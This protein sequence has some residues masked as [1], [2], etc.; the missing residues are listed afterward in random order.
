MSTG[1]PSAL[2]GGELAGGTSAAGRPPG[3]RSSAFALPA[4]TSFR[5]ALL[6]AAVLA[7]SV[8]VY[9]GIYLATPRGLAWVRLNRRCTSQALA[10][11]RGGMTAYAHALGQA[12]VCRSGA[13]RAEALWVVVGL[14]V[15]AVLAA[16]IYGAQP[17]WYRRRMRLA[18]LTGQDAPALMSRLEELRGHAGAGPVEWLLQPLNT[19]VSAFAFG[20]FRRRSVAVSGGAAV[21]AVRQP[22]AFDAVMLHE[23]AH[24]RNRDIS[25]TYLAVAIW[26]AFV[27]AALLPMAVLLVVGRDLGSPLRILWRVVVLA[28]TVYLLRNTI[29]RSREFDADARVQELDPDTG[30]G[31]VLDG[32]PARPGRRLW[33]LGWMHP[34]GPERATALLDPRPLYRCG[35]WDGLAVGLVTTIGASAAQDFMPQ[36]TT[37]NFLQFLVPAGLFA[38]FAAAAL[39]I[40]MWRKQLLQPQTETG[41]GGWAAGLGL[42]IGLAIGPVIALPTA[43]ANGIIPDSISLAAAGFLAAWIALTIVIYLPF[44]VWMGYWADAWQQAAGKTRR[45]PARG[46][47]I[48][49]SVA[50]WVVLTFGLY[51]LLANFVLFEGIVAE[52]LIRQVEGQVWTSTVMVTAGMTGAW[53]VCL[54]MVAV[55]LTPLL[56]SRRRPRQV[57]QRGTAWWFR[58]AVRVGALC[59]AGV[60]AAAAVTLTVSAVAHAWVAAPVR[61]DAFFLAQLIFFDTQAVVVVAV[62]FAIIAAGA[63]RSLHSFTIGVAVAAIVAALGIM[64]VINSDNIGFCVGAVSIQYTY[65]PAGLCPS[66]LGGSYLVQQMWLYAVEAALVSI[67]FIPAAHRFGGALARFRARTPKGAVVVGMIGAGAAVIVAVAATGFWGAET[68]THNI[69]PPGSIGDDGW[70]SAPGYEMR[71]SPK[72]FKITRTAYPGQ[73]FIVYSVHG[74]VIEIY[75]EPFSSALTSFQDFPR[76]YKL[77]QV[78]TRP[79]VIGGVRGPGVVGTGAGEAVYEASLVR[80]GPF[81]YVVAFT[82]PASDRA[83][84]ESELAQMLRTW[85]WKTSA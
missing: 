27:V 79:A 60:L 67:V 75:R 19:R 69:R 81:G 71:L 31:R 29:L 18:P 44:P 32:M 64:V 50:A 61:W 70:I 84:P 77:H 15:L 80:H 76:L 55:P 85:H 20:S 11:N 43:F 25:Q 5:F 73:T 45:I 16:V 52:P 72:W 23:L 59:L 42:G 38:A 30:L 34:S 54:V 26:R 39:V 28:L 3:R 40:A 22:V 62:L 2:P 33:H 68:S 13:D 51:F 12:A 10:H 24:I 46:G 4:S 53:I 14:G 56:A 35:F 57:D 63:I 37:I 8:F 83:A 65:P 74:S 21:A 41:T 36:L 47:M 7:S 78:R 48:A 9:E 58:R 66:F 49:A 82:T 1:P 17:W 6:I